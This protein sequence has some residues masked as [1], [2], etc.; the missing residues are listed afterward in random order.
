MFEVVLRRTSILG[1]NLLRQC[2]FG[3][4]GAESVC[5]RAEQYKSAI[6]KS[7]G[8]DPEQRVQK[9]N[10]IRSVRHQSAVA[11]KQHQPKGADGRI[12]PLK[13]VVKLGGLEQPESGRSVDTRDEVRTGGA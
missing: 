1:R 9:P 4:V 11:Q 5:Y 8:R 2:G 7:G 6:K 13:I 3:P 12:P 10:R